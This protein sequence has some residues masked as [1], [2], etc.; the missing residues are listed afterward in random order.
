MSAPRLSARNKRWLIHPTP[1]EFIAAFRQFPPLI[2]AV[3]YQRGLRSESAIREFFSPDYR[4]NDPFG[5][6]GMETAVQRIVAAIQNHEP[7]A[8]Y[9]DYDTDGVTA[10]ALL[11]QV[12]RAMGGMIQPYVPH[13]VREGYGLNIAAIDALAREGVRLLITV[14]CGISNVREA[15]HARAA[16]LD[17][18]I[19][20]HHEPPARLPNALAIVNPKQ[21][22]CPYPFKHL[23]GVGIAYQL[24]RALV[25]RGLR[26]TLQKDDLL[27]IVA[28]GTVA[29]MGPLVGE[30]RVLVTHGLRALNAAQRPGVRALIEAAGLT[31]GR[32][33]STDI[34]FGLG[35]RLNASG[36]IDNARLSYE[37]L[38]AEEL[39]IAYH[40]ARE[41]NVQNRQR[42]EL[43]KNVQEQASAQIRALG[44]HHQ[45]IIVLD[46]TGYP[47]GVVGLVA[48]RLVEEFGR[49]TVL[50]ERGEAWSRGSARSVPGF[51]MI[52]ALTACADLL[53]RFGGHTEAAGFTIATDRLPEL[54]AR[55]L[56]YAEQRLPDDLLIPSLRVD[57]EVPL[58]EL[59]Y[60][61]LKELTRLEPFGQGNPQPVLM[62]SRV[63]VIGAWPR[64]SEGQH[65]KLRLTDA[66]GAGPFDAIA[67]RFGHL[68]RYFEQPRW[69]DIAYTLES[70]E[71]NGTAALQLNIKDFRSAR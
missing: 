33:T 69:I 67:F 23:V 8:V 1:P 68:A 31:P 46:D 2:A 13:R 6:R 54:E 11:V 16:G 5:L 14:D 50:I 53:E 65:L 12:I 62:S 35:P 39:D 63:Q 17:L 30:N 32:V 48:A 51:S 60:D 44:K 19:T 10:V 38:L 47:A 64:G 7:M 29:D 25:R 41:L 28:I 9:G 58:S 56:H 71:W 43:S 3:L 34:S 4:L 59:S 66:S 61:L 24:A 20:D 55:L 18:I 36:R 70:D 45:R 22:G 49:P 21:P 57:A 40:L 42:Q 52:E 26:S 37:L 15:E 27:D